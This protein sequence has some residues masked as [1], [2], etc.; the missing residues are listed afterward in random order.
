[1]ATIPSLLGLRSLD[2]HEPLLKAIPFLQLGPLGQQEA[3]LPQL[4]LSVLKAGLLQF[5]SVLGSNGQQTV[6][7]P[8][9]DLS[10]LEAGLL[11]FLADLGET[12]SQLA[13][14]PDGAAFPMWVIAA[15]GAGAACA[16]AYRQQR[17]SADGWETEIPPLPGCSMD[18][19][20]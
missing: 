5:L 2:R 19:A 1:M 18:D 9:P 13:I 14:G 3:P 15:V 4:Q 7:L 6:P 20:R 17:R 16:L 12:S 8:I 11:Q 10:T